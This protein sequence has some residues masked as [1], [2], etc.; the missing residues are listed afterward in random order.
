M[1]KLKSILRIEK[2]IT[3]DNFQL[4]YNPQ[5]YKKLQLFIQEA[6]F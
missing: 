2:K 3:F 1:A 5:G 6:D 4:I